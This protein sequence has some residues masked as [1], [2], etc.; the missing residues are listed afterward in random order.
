MAKKKKGPVYRSV[1]VDVHDPDPN[2]MGFFGVGKDRGE[3]LRKLTRKVCRVLEK[4][5]PENIDI[6]TVSISVNR[7]ERLVD[8]G[9]TPALLGTATITYSECFSEG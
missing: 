8:G 9:M 5:L 3:V 6:H 4:Q 7:T 2:R 1:T